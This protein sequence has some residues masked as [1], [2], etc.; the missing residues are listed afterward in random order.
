M[1]FDSLGFNFTLNFT[2]TVASV[3]KKH[4]K[5]ITWRSTRIADGVLFG[6]SVIGFSGELYVFISLILMFVCRKNT[7]YCFENNSLKLN[8][9]M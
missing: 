3:V 7:I 1:S 2:T 9:T 6:L 8:Q 4:D 5:E